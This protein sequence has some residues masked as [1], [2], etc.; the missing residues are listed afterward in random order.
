MGSK[1]GEKKKVGLLLHSMLV[2][3]VQMNA[4]GRKPFTIMIY[5]LR[6]FEGYIYNSLKPDTDER[7]RPVEVGAQ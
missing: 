3:P 1:E 2:S 6:A 4:D 5:L 7:I